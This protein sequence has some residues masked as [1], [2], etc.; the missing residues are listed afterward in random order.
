M[1]RIVILAA[2]TVITAMPAASA[3]DLKSETPAET[4]VVRGKLVPAPPPSAGLEL[5]GRYSTKSGADM[6][7]VTDEETEDSRRL[8]AQPS[9]E[10]I[11]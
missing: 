11:K 6:P 8:P 1:T 2:A 5:R 10:P 9:S 4:R 7:D 3:A